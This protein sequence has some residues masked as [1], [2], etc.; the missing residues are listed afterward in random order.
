MKRS[1]PL[2]P[3]LDSG[4]VYVN[5]TEY[6]SLKQIHDIISNVFVTDIQVLRI[7]DTQIKID[8]KLKGINTLKKYYKN[9]VVMLQL[10]VFD[11]QIKNYIELVE[12]NPINNSNKNQANS[13]LIKFEKAIGDE[14]ADICYFSNTQDKPFKRGLFNV[15]NKKFNIQF[16]FP[17]VDRPLSYYPSK[18]NRRMK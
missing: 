5:A 7:N 1:N 9:E 14:Y 15:Y 10:K 16:F 4:Y 18:L 3:H 2:I 17:K 11:D 6:D 13:V 12:K 8:F